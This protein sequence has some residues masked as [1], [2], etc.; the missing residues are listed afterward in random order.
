MRSNSS[1]CFDYDDLQFF[2]FSF[3]L[4]L[5][6]RLPW[7]NAAKIAHLLKLGNKTWKKSK[8]FSFSAIL[9]KSIKH[10]QNS[11]QNNSRV[12]V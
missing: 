6:I 12:I 5:T 3:V 2:I 4:F 1:K 7:V 11:I 8:L 9:S 10:N